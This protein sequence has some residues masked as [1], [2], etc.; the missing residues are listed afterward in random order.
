M[1]KRTVFEGALDLV[2]HDPVLARC[3]PLLVEQNRDFLADKE[4]FAYLALDSKRAKTLGFFMDLTGELANAPEL[5]EQAQ[6]L[7]SKLT[8]ETELE[9]FFAKKLSKRRRLVAEQTTPQVAKK[10]GFLLN[11]GL[12]SFASH[13]RKCSHLKCPSL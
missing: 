13:F 1:S 2:H 5:S 9:P 4:E 12:D 10:W 6:A 7:F 8:K 11:I 3:F